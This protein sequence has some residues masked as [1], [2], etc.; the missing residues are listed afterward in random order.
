[1]TEKFDVVA[2]FSKNGNT[3][4]EHLI[5]NHLAEIE[6]IKNDPNEYRQIKA[7]KI[8][9]LEKKIAEIRQGAQERYDDWVSDLDW[10]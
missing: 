1:M 9:A 4:Y 10:A 3:V 2:W 8:I 6:E 7:N 5:N